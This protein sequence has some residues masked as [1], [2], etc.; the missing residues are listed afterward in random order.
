MHFIIL[1]KFTLITIYFILNQ[2]NLLSAGCP[3]LHSKESVQSLVTMLGKDYNI[4]TR[5]LNDSCITINEELAVK[6]V[7]RSCNYTLSA[8]INQCR[9]PPVIIE[10]ICT[11]SEMCKQ[12]FIATLIEVQECSEHDYSKLQ[13]LAVYQRKCGC[14]FEKL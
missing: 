4:S 3:P 11:E 6:D 14:H 1:I 12:A 5:R 7:T 8:N 9:E 2:F 13:D 10:A